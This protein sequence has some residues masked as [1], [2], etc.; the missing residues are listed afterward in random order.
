[1]TIKHKLMVIIMVTCTVA[2]WLYSA[3][4]LLSERK[5]FREETVDSISCYAEM[6]GDNCRA[7]LA[8]EDAEDTRETLKSLQAESSIVYAC[9]YTKKHQ[10][11]ADY[12]RAG[13]NEDFSPPGC[14]E[15]GYRFDGKYFKLFKQI[16]EGDGS[17]G[18][19]YVQLDLSVGRTRLWWKAGMIAL[20]VVV[21][22]LMAY[23][24]SLRLQ[25]VISEPLLSL[26]QVAKVVSE[27]EDYSVRASKQSNDEVGTLIDAFNEMLMQI[28]ERDSALTDAKTKL[29]TRVRERTAE[30]SLAYRRTEGLNRLKGNL[31]ST[32]GLTEKLKCITDAVVETF[33]ADFVRVWFIKPGDRCDS[34]CIHAK[35]QEESHVCRD[36]DRCLHLIASSGR[37]THIDGQAHRRV[38]FGCYKIGTIASGEKSKFLT[39][40]VIHDPG[41]HNHSWAR[42]LGLVS[43]VGYR[44][45]SATGE[46][47]GVFALFSKHVISDEEDTLLEGVA[48]TTSQV[49]QMAMAE[50]E[51]ERTHQ[52]L[53]KTSHQAGMAEVA[54]DV[55]HNV[56]NVLNSINVSANYIQD[57]VLDSKAK[58]LKKVID[59]ISEHVEDLSTFLTQDERG[60]H[61][62]V[63]LSEAAK[64]LVH[65]H[66][67]I[68]EK[69]RSLMKNVEHV[70][71]II[72]AQ[73]GYAR[74]G[75]VKVLMNINEVIED[76][77]EINSAILSRE[78]VH[79][80]LDLAELPKVHL[81]KQRVLQI[82]VNLITNAENALSDSDQQDKLLVIRCYQHSKDTLRI[83]VEDNG[84]GIPKENL[85]KIFRHGFTTRKDG[86]G[87]GLHS[88]ALTAIELGGGLTV[89]SDGLGHGAT[90]TLEL[91]F[92][93]KTENQKSGDR[94]S[95]KKTA[96]KR[97]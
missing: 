67:G 66:S 9:V 31:L 80:E 78:E 10:M 46:S 15:E 50:E 44:L 24:V 3:I 6:I 4:H 63:Y 81:D 5:E 77:I 43:F 68:S 17:I 48:N 93:T 72:K 12:Q 27:K 30:L 25:R 65:E 52:R 58:N 92:R 8:F 70:K 23:L 42:E 33:G 82:L 64:L 74:A 20:V 51:L 62:P 59:M 54:T 89:H 94:T 14:E 41:I 55:L 37:Y 87:F 97:S 21:C 91:P 45:V 1:M 83:D 39:N 32:K 29:E 53:I 2:L 18:T 84:V 96:G 79:L 61:I 69:V 47:V 75:G 38:P 85:A 35:I 22:S 71:Q 60:K 16:K 28:Q 11:L 56:G 19:V 26:T 13:L 57:T 95:G 88:S 7:A 90:F 34:G 86:H 49:I 76:A 73:Q 36:R 40:D